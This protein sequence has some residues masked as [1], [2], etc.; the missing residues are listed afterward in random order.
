LDATTVLFAISVFR[1]FLCRRATIIA[2]EVGTVKSQEG[3]AK[4]KPKIEAPSRASKAVV[5]V[6]KSPEGPAKKKLKI[7]ALLAP[8]KKKPEPEKPK[9]AA[10]EPLVDTAHNPWPDATGKKIVEEGVKVAFEEEGHQYHLQDGSS[11]YSDWII[12]CSGLIRYW[13]ECVKVCACGD[14]NVTDVVVQTKQTL[15]RY[16]M[17]QVPRPKTAEPEGP[18]A[19]FVRAMLS[20]YLNEFAASNKDGPSTYMARQDRLDALVPPECGKKFRNHIRHAVVRDLENWLLESDTPTFTESDDEYMD[21]LRYLK[22]PQTGFG[23]VTAKSKSG[24]ALCEFLETEWVRVGAVSPMTQREMNGAAS[25]LAAGAGTVAHRYIECHLLGIDEVPELREVEDRESIHAMLTYLN[26]K[27]ISFEKENL[28]KRVGSMLYKICGS[29]DALRKRDDGVYEI[30]DWKRTQYAKEWMK[31][32][33]QKHPDDPHHWVCDF[34]KVNFSDSLMTYHIQMAGYH[35]VESHSNPDRV[36]SNSA[37]LGAIHPSLE[38]GFVI[39]ELRLDVKMKPAAL[40]TTKGI[41]NYTKDGVSYECT[42]GLTSLEY[43]KCL[44]HHRLEHLK[45]HYRCDPCIQL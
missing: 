42:E 16:K 27:N 26:E 35:Q 37:F 31:N 34:S 29:M 32:A 9:W 40:P 1:H 21:V 24:R 22:C 18:H 14:A 8:K 28:E 23:H 15:D 33:T 20:A 3:P 7:D 13:G 45:R 6:N 25:V 41:G 2:M 44:M 4:K 19:K 5:V 10:P 30:W 36:L 39:L 38:C 11:A 43:V 12:S 17:Q